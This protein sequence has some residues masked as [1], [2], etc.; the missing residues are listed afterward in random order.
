MCRRPL[1]TAVVKWKKKRNLQ[2]AQDKLDGLFGRKHFEQTVA[3]QDDEPA[4]RQNGV[5]ANHDPGVRRQG[6]VPVS[7][8]VGCELTPPQVG[9]GD[10]PAAFVLTISNGTGHLQNSQHPAV[11]THTRPID[12]H[13]D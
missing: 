5:L 2:D 9:R 8:V 3:G 4:D 10:D 1:I 6:P 7:P 11:P 12:H 13:C